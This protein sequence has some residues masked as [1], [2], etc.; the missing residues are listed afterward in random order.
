[1]VVPARVHTLA[2]LV[3]T[4]SL[5]IRHR[6]APHSSARGLAAT[7]MR[8][9][10]MT[11]SRK[12]AQTVRQGMIQAAI[13]KNTTD[14]GPYYAVTFERRYRDG[15]EWKSTHGFG[16][17]DLLALAKV[18]DLAHTA[19]HDL[20]NADKARQDKGAGKPGEIDLGEDVP[21][22]PEP[23]TSNRTAAANAASVDQRRGR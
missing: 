15:E 4:C 3:S 7:N 2:I 14:K 13:W 5:L 17:D 19:I 23:G 1:M 9:D 11:E 12:P 6:V 20:Q 10:R 16:R 18:A 21:G 22:E 8:G